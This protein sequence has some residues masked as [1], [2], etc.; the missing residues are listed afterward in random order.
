[1]SASSKSVL[2]FGA[3]GGV[4]RAAALAT[5][6]NGAKVWLA[7]RD[8]NK[9]I[10]GLTPAL[11]EE[12]GFTRVQADLASPLSLTAVVAKSGATSAFVYTLHFSEDYMQSAFKALKDAGITYIVLL[13]S[14]GVQPSAAEAMEHSFIPRVHAATEIKLRESGID[15]VALRPA[16]FNTN[17]FWLNGW[18]AGHIETFGVTSRHDFLAPEDIG[19]VAGNLLTKPNLLG[20]G[21]NQSEKSLY[22][23]GPKV[24]SLEEAVGIVSS[25][26]KKDIKLVEMGEEKFREK[27]SAAPKPMLDSM[28]DVTTRSTP[29]N[30]MYPEKLWGEGSE[31]TRRYTQREPT[32]FKDWAE[33][34]E[35]AFV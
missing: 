7:M 35:D 32:A 30:N 26:L 13:S 34:N 6:R 12:A 24:M 3:A 1:M 22:L 20:A 33:A 2:I 17:L 16:Y 29:P 14:Y 5:S 11:E 18:K 25:V 31:N 10:P 19:A 21:Y 23:C 28:V 27:N 9:P 4:G 8:T 15:F